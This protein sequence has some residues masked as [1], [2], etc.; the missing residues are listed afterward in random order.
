VPNI[1]SIVTAVSFLTCKNVYEFTHTHT[2]TKQEE[3]D[4]SEVHRTIQNCRYSV[5][6]LL[7]VS[8]LAPRF[9][10]NMGNPGHKLLY[11]L[12]TPHLSKNNAKNNKILHSQ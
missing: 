4:N 9:L 2:H 6:N 8:F 5:S 12:V 10:D 11:G 7:N 3:P 1:V